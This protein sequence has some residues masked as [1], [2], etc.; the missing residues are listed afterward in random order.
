MNSIFYLNGS[1]VMN[2]PS[3]KPTPDRI[4]AIA[5]WQELLQDSAALLA[6]PGAQHKELVRPAHTL[7][8]ARLIDR[9]DL[10]DLLEQA[11]GAQT[12]AIEAALDRHD[13]E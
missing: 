12:Y 13:S 10:C 5:S 11:D 9:Y 3:V 6:Q 8:Q 7:H 4:R 1:P 2:Y